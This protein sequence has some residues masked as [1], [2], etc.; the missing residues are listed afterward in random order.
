MARLI[1][2]SDG[3][4][5]RV[6]DLKLGINRVGRSPDSDLFIDHV[7]VSGLHCEISIVD[8]EL[9]IRDCHSTNGTFYQGTPINEIR[10]SAGQTFQ[11]GEVE[12]LVESTEVAVSIP[13]FELPRPASSVAQ[14]HGSMLCPPQGEKKKVK[15]GFLG[16]L[17]KTVKMSF[18]QSR[19]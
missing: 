16:F 1:L 13:K 15:K 14:T 12:V 4:N 9:L 19:K 7:T 11:V 5:D 10:L 3:F 17:Q 18:L 8:N 2:K 6:F